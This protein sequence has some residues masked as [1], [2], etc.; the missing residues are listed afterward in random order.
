MIDYT[1]L[2]VSSFVLVQPR[3]ATARPTIMST[4]C[5]S[6]PLCAVTSVLS[7]VKEPMNLNEGVSSRVVARFSDDTGENGRQLDTR[8]GM[9]NKLTI[10]THLFHR[11]TGN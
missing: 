6:H 2:S 5:N 11:I 4:N 9:P 1:D 10:V 8:S 3:A 7:K